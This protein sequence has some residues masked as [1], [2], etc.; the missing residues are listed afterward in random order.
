MKN[1]VNWAYAYIH[2]LVVAWFSVAR[3]SKSISVY[4]QLQKVVNT[5]N[6][7]FSS[8]HI[9]YIWRSFGWIQSTKEQN[10]ILYNFGFRGWAASNVE[11]YSTFRQ[12]LQLPSSGWI[13]NGWAFLET[14]YGVGS[15]WCHLLHVLSTACVVCPKPQSTPNRQTEL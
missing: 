10:L 5:V 1:N 4:L 12:T 15:R 6:V 11:N 14:L 7:T 9:A 8:R 13:C 2:S 3:G